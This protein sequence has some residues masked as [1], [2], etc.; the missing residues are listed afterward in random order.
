MFLTKT[1]LAHLY[2]MCVNTVDKRVM[3]MAA[4]GNY[5]NA[6][7]MH[8]RAVLIDPDEFD[9]FTRERALKEL[10]RRLNGQG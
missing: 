8:K 4:T 3:E 10:E 2:G 9:R 6:F 1:E 5:P 7:K